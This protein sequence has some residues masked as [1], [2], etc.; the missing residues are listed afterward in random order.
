MH[1][2]AQAELETAITYARQL[3]DIEPWREE[4]HRELMRLLALSGQRSAA[5]MQYE[6]C[7]RVLDEELAVEPAPA[8][9][10]LYEQ[11]RQN[12][13]GKVDSTR[14]D[15][16]TMAELLLAD[17]SKSAETPHHNLPLQLSSFIGRKQ[18]M[19][20]VKRLLSMS[21]LLTLTGAGGCG[22]TRLA[23][24][25]VTT[26]LDTYTDGIWV[27][28]LAPLS[29]IALV[30]QAVAS[31]LGLRE[32]SDQPC[33][34]V[35]LRYLQA[36]HLLLVLD[37][38]EHLIEAT[39]QL[40]DA[41][42][43]HCPYLQILTTSRE[44]LNIAGEVV[45]LVPSLSLP[46]SSEPLPVEILKQYDAI[47]LFVERAM[48][49]LPTFALTDQ[50]AATVAQVC[51][52]LDGIPLAIELA[53]A[54]V[55]VLRVE[56]IAIRLDNRFRLLTGGS[57]TALPRHQTLRALIDWSYKLL[58]PAEQLLLRHL[59]VFAGGFTLEAVEAIWAGKEGDILGLLTQL[60][61]KSLVV[62]EREQGLE[63]R[64]R[65]LETI[66]Q[67]M[68][69]KLVESGEVKKVRGR[70]LDFFL[71]VVEKD[72][73]KLH[74]TEQLML[75]SRLE[76]EHDN[77]RAAL[78][79]AWEQ[80]VAEIVA[81]LGGA[82]GQF[83]A[84]RGYLGEGRQW[85]GRILVQRERISTP[86]LAKVLFS[87]G[88]LLFEQANY[89]QAQ[90]YYEESLKLWREIGNS[91][92]IA[93]LLNSLGHVAQQQSDYTRA[94][95]LS[96][97]SL[98]LY[99]D[100]DD[101]AGIALSLNRLGHIAQLQGDYAYAV[102]LVE[103]SLT[104]RRELDDKRGIASSLNFLA[105]T[106]RREGQYERAIAL[107]EESL[108]L[109]QKLGDKRCIAGLSH[110]LGHV[111]QEQ[112]DYERATAMFKR[113]LALYQ[114]LENRPGVAL[115]LAGLA[116]IMGKSGQLRH[117]VQ[118]LGAVEAFFETFNMAMDIV[119]HVT[120]ERTVATLR[121]QL[122]EDTFSAV[123]AEG[124][125]MPLQQAVAYALEETEI[126]VINAPPS[127]EKNEPLK[128]FQLR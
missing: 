83:W 64:Y 126:V 65:L 104:L 66:Q 61:N 82:L 57:R 38:C 119:D 93:E 50:N 8:T 107:Y 78:Q 101:K 39:A 102:S 113:S 20:E 14:A 77:L 54:R 79:W 15:T 70:H 10:T 13:L 36:K 49:A 11:I 55:K 85:L 95:A 74:G 97:E 62:S 41:L 5:L 46:E 115:C 4:A 25:M 63:A 117:A 89:S 100:L 96:M 84:I 123:W 12:Q 92:N 99:R 98:T 87:Y 7:R 53:A 47:R 23:L 60:V 94:V 52:K 26:V 56:Q 59:S 106:A 45:W 124:R 51:Q 48:T 3:L 24:Q 27:V 91:E 28:E 122:H 9:V 108:L 22:K 40:A 114:K 112:G 76:V 127:S 16:P 72:E 75:L 31:V 88:W 42:L 110:N 29:D 58:S 120:Y 6:M 44:T 80:E 18:E 1:F 111:I 90:Q 21:R 32:D 128:S 103:E 105:E 30:P 43:R 17:L 116:G 118:I 109:C 73:T 81:R 37:N 33:L 67:Y 19:A 86:T 34:T 35:L 125:A 71:Q 2:A 68:L 69:E 121:K